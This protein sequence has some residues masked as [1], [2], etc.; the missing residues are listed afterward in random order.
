MATEGK[1]VYYSVAEKSWIQDRPEAHR[2]ILDF[3]F[4]PHLDRQ[5]PARNTEAWFVDEQEYVRVLTLH[6]ILRLN[7]TGSFIWTLAD[8]HRTVREIFDRC[9]DE[10]PDSPPTLEAEI[11]KFLSELYV[12]SLLEIDRRPLDTSTQIELDAELQFD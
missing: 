3:F 8:S 12:I 2:E 4:S 9:R 1:P 5:R 6:G 10:W 11:R 7:A